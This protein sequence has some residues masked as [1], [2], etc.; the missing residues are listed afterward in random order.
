MPNDII[1]ISVPD[2][3]IHSKIMYGKACV[4]VVVEE[5]GK[6]CRWFVKMDFGFCSLVWVN[7]FDP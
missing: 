2:S 7:R 4:H 6:K 3:V 5:A 1:D